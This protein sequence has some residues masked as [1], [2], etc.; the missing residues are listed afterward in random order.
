MSIRKEV[1]TILILLS[2]FIVSACS[3]DDSM[4]NSVADE[5][6]GEIS[7]TIDGE[8]LRVVR[9]KLSRM[10]ARRIPLPSI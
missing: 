7:F 9:C 6:S 3:D 4:S 2:F 1:R 5:P 10:M 8:A